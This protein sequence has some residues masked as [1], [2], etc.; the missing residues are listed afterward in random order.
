MK[1]DSEHIKINLKCIKDLN[2]RPKSIKFIEESMGQS[3]M[4]LDLA[5]DFLN[6]IPKTQAAKPK[7]DK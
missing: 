4:T 1:L 5:I 7:I 2:I 3:F 6:M